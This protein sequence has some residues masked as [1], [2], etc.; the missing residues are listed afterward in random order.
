MKTP[1]SPAMSLLTSNCERPQNEHLLNFAI[2]QVDIK[3]GMGMLSKD[4]SDKL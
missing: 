2:G 3:R 1:S 4:F